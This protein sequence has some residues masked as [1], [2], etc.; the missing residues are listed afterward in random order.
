MITFY[1]KYP[2]FVVKFDKRII[3]W[4]YDIGAEQGEL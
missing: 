3:L 4:R 2:G 1:C